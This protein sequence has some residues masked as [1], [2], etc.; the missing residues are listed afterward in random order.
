M[1]AALHLRPLDAHD[2]L[3]DWVGGWSEIDHLRAAIV[4]T[5]AVAS[6]AALA[7][8]ALD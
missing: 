3:L 1:T 5:N 4:A 8:L 6:R 7:G 2:L